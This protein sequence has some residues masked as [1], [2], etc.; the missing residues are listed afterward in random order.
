MWKSGSHI[1]YLFCAALMIPGGWLTAQ[2]AIVI[3]D[4]YY[5]NE[6]HKGPG[7]DFIRYHYTWE[8]TANSGFS[9]LGGIFRGLGAIT[10]SLAVAP[11]AGNLSRAAV[12]IIVDPDDEREVP[13]PHFPSS[14][15][16]RAIEDWVKSGGV[17]L[18]MSN[19]S[20]NADFRHFNELAGVFGIQF[21]CDDYHKVKGTQYDMGAFDLEGSGPVFKRSG[22]VYIKDLSTLSVRPPAR[23]YF[24][25]S[26]RVIMATAK[27][28]R[29][30]VFAVGDPWFY[31]E[32]MA[33][34]RL[35]S[36]YDNHLAAGE[37]AQWLL[38]QAR[39]KSNK[40]R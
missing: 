34:G 28:G 10:D 25:D 19:D 17:L 38:S 24:S 1:I 16:I 6:R 31:N 32:Y 11:T 18:L 7:G 36:A 39:R 35:P 9:Q 20:A 30:T 37:M 4:Y 22:R 2:K 13:D 8:D 27:V 12:Y 29:G 3:L 21:N 33:G 40:S 26:G 14:A 5:N 15:A 23:A